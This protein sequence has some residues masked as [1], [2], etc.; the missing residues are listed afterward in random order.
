MDAASLRHL[1][2]AF[3]PL[4]TL[5]KN[6]VSG[7]PCSVETAR[8][9]FLVGYIG[10]GVLAFAFL[11]LGTGMMFGSGETFAPQGPVFST[12][13]VDLYSATLGAW[14][15][16]GGAGG[17]CHHD[18][19]DDA[20]R[21]RRGPRAIERSLVVLRA[22][23]ID[24]HP[25]A[26]APAVAGGPIYWWSLAGVVAITLVTLALFIGNLTTMIDF[27]TTLTF[28]T[29]PV[30]GYLNLRAVGSDEVPAEHRPGPAMLI[31]SW[32]GLVLL[33]GTG[34]FYL[35]CQ[36][37]PERASFWTGRRPQHVGGV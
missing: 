27:A 24:P 13:L 1:K 20:D 3:G 22:G 33:G 4:W 19:V 16:A 23:S 31:L 30:L 28:L 37:S 36:R 6:D 2:V 18:A 26:G 35:I 11:T 9:N 17:G 25:A 15:R 5:A 14:T 32:V 34:L 10:T 29:S 8:Q 21:A 7:R 12:P